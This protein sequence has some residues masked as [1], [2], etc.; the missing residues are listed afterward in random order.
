MK[1]LVLLGAPALVVAALALPA[2][3]ASATTSAACADA[4]LVYREKSEFPDTP[5]GRLDHM[6]QDSKIEQAVLCLVNT[7]RTVRGL[8]PVKRYIGLRGRPVALRSATTKQVLAAV[9]IRWWGTVAQVGDCTPLKSDPSRCDVHINPETGTDPAARAKAAG[10]CRTGTSWAVG[11]NAYLGWGRA[12]VT[13][14]AAVTWW[15]G[16]PPHRATIL[17][18]GYTEMY[19]RAAYGSADPSVSATP[20]MTYVQMFGRCS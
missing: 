19:T 12:F 8:Q 11:E 4:D 6:M 15:M 17:T 1:S 5:R 18:P 10:Y 20:A 9:R 16:S 3:P 2:A 7:E 14:R 13:P